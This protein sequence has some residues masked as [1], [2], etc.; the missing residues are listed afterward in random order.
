MWS[1]GH[2]D[3]RQR[4]GRFE[5][6]DGLTPVVLHQRHPP[7]RLGE[8]A[9]VGG[10]PHRPGGGERATHRHFGLLIPLQ[11][12]QRDAEPVIVPHLRVEVAGRTG[13]A[14]GLAMHRHR[15]IGHTVG[16]QGP[17]EHGKGIGQVSPGGRV[18]GPHQRHC[19][20]Q[21][22]QRR[23]WPRGG[24]RSLAPASP[25]PG[26]EQRVALGKGNRV[27]ALDQGTLLQALHEQR[28][29]VER[30]ELA[31]LVSGC[32]E[33]IARG[34]PQRSRL[35]A[36]SLAV[37]QGADVSAGPAL[38]VTIADGRGRFERPGQRV[39]GFDATVLF[40][41]RSA[42]PTKRLGL[43]RSGQ[44]G[45]VQERRKGLLGRDELAPIEL[46][47]GEVERGCYRGRGLRV[48]RRRDQCDRD[49]CEKALSHADGCYFRE[50]SAAQ[51][52]A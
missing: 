38:V 16:A 3:A 2:L 41:Q 31:A 19:A 12:G 8:Q 24:E 40:E 45:L 11:L 9:D 51:A 27:A 25:H 4:E 30:L 49:H 14:D 43:L 42:Q 18:E 1:G 36:V 50:A 13:Q 33:V 10:G 7:Q 5:N 6:A 39:G 46:G 35:V 29:V 17:A 44:P 26:L 34:I 23:P 22:D 20:L 15:A 21:F 47:E 52:S 48:E 37:L 32:H 28:E